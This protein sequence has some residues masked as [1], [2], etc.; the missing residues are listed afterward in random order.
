MEY[1]L[2]NMFSWFY[3]HTW[4]FNVFF[5]MIHCHII[6]KYI[7]ISTSL[8]VI[9]SLSKSF[10]LICKYICGCFREMELLYVTILGKHYFS[11]ARSLLS[12]CFIFVLKFAII[13]S[14][15]SLE[16]LLILNINYWELLSLD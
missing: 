16:Y 1:N 15:I 7:C 3:S 14:S 13:L 9:I 8:D 5:S 12:F 10:V 11:C 2:C 4:M 6:Y